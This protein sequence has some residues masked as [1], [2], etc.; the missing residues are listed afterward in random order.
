MLI[1]IAISCTGTLMYFNGFNK[2]SIASV[3]SIGVVVKDSIL[4]PITKSESLN[5]SLIVK[6]I[7][8]S[9]IVNIHQD[10]KT[11]PSSYKNK[12]INPVN[13]NRKI[14]NF[15]LLSTI[16]SGIFATIVTIVKKM[17]T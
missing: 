11:L 17:H 8:L 15:M 13:I 12:L 14:I 16:F 2:L 3:S 4:V 9:V 10:A 6:S 1:V 5:A 7:P